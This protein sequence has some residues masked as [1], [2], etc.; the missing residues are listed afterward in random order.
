MSPPQWPG[1][2]EVV[3]GAVEAGETLLE[4]VLREI[5]EELG[6]RIRVRPLGVL[7][8]YTFP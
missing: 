6:E 2:W 8:A 4:A 7:H 3:S 1:R 5:R